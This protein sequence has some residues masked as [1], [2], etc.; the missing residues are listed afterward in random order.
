MGAGASV[1]VVTKEQCQSLYGDLFND[2]EWAK[3]AV[4][5]VVTRDKL[6]TVFAALADAFLTHDW[7]TDGTTHKNVSVVNTLLKARGITTWF[8]EE[9]MEGNVKKQMIHGIDNARAIVVFVTQRYI[10]KVGGNNAEDNCQLEF[11]YAARRKTASKM[12]PVLIDPSPALKKT[13]NWTGE[14]GFVL[15]GH[16]Y[17]DLSSAAVFVENEITGEVLCGV[18]SADEVKELGVTLAPK[19]RL[20]FDKLSEFKASGV[21]SHLLKATEPSPP[22]L[23]STPPHK[24]FEELKAAILPSNW[25]QLYK[26]PLESNGANILSAHKL[27]WPTPACSVSVLG[28]LVTT[29]DY[30]DMMKDNWEF[31]RLEALASRLDKHEFLLTFKIKVAR[32]DSTPLCAG[33]NPWFAVDITADLCLIIQCNRE[34]QGFVVQL[35]GNPWLM[36]IDTW[37]DVAVLMDVPHSVIQVVIN[38]DR[39]DT[40]PLP[41]AFTFT[42]RDMPTEGNEFYLLRRDTMTKLFSG[43]LRKIELYS[44]LPL[45]RPQ[46]VIEGSDPTSHVRHLSQLAEWTNGLNCLCNYVDMKVNVVDSVDGTNVVV[47]SAQRPARFGLTILIFVGTAMLLPQGSFIHP[48][49]G[50][51][52]DGDY[53]GEAY[54]QSAM[55]RAGGNFGLHL[56]NYDF[57][58]ATRVATVGPCYVMNMG[59][60]HRYFVVQITIQRNL[61]VLLNCHS[62]SHDVKEKGVILTLEH[63][64]WHDI[65]VK[66]QGKAI[67][68]A[69]DGRAMDTIALTD[70]FEFTAGPGEDTKLLL[71]NFSCGGCFYGYM[72][73]IALWSSDCPVEVDDNNTVLHL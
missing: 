2:A 59:S 3:Q 15:G 19:A 43:H 18:E 27:T 49:L 54:N 8:D 30:A 32:G 44:T 17:L 5:G 4:D 6:T 16:L 31:Y 69:V 64:A 51:Y 53:Y 12:I 48:E 14:V 25:V 72:A 22:A 63:N 7:G 61:A 37:L 50:T 38:T 47:E 45:T 73:S 28:G 39:M 10:D 58:F 56:N 26:Y 67:H 65:A 71:V 20:L 70:D 60:S 13:A 62:V 9:K 55:T 21:P 33:Y 24:S 66:M 42:T 11:N 1:D 41:P 57:V 35:N 40:I 34:A 46:P 36:P 52:F 68:V 29:G 23:V